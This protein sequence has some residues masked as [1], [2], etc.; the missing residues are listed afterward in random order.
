MWSNN[1]L[2]CLLRGHTLLDFTY[3]GAEYRYC[4]R[5]GKIESIDAFKKNS[6]AQDSSRHLTRETVSM[7]RMTNITK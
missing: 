3:K 1:Y 6:S 2:F 4:L 5:C 7:L